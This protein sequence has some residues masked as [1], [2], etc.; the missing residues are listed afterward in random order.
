MAARLELLKEQFFDNDGAV[1][2]GGLLYTYV[3]GTTTEKATYTTAL[4]DVEQANPVVLDT[5]G[6]VATDLYGV[7][8]YKIVIKDS[9]E[10]TIDTIP[11]VSGVNSASFTTI[12]DYSGDLDAAITAISTT[13]TTLYIN[14]AATM[15]AAVTV[16]TTCKIVVLTGGSINQSTYAL[17]ING[18]F[19]A[20]PKQVFTGSGTV[21]FGLISE[22][23]VE[24]MGNIDGTA[25]D[26][27]I[28]LAIGA[29]AN[30]QTIK[31][32]ASTYTCSS[33]ITLSK[34]CTFSIGTTAITSTA[35]NAFTITSDDVSIVGINRMKSKIISSGVG[36][37]GI[38][39][40]SA[41]RD[42]ITIRDLY[43]EGPSTVWVAQDRDYEDAI[44]FGASTKVGYISNVVIRDCYFYGY[45]TFIMAF[46]VKN[47]QIV[48]NIFNHDFAALR[49]INMWEP[50]GVL[51]QGNH[52]L[53]SGQSVNA[54]EI[55]GPADTKAQE[56]KIDNNTFKG[57]W[58]YEIVNFGGDRSSIV[59]NYLY[60]SATAGVQAIELKQG[61][62][63]SATTVNDITI[64]DNTIE[65][66]NTTTYAIGIKND[67]ATIA[68]TRFTIDNNTILY[69]GT[70]SAIVTT[71]AGGA[72]TYLD[73][74]NNK[75]IDSGNGTD[76][77][78]LVT[79]T[80]SARIK[81]NFVSGCGRYGIYTQG[82]DDCTISGNE[83]MSTTTSGYFISGANVLVTNNSAHDNTA[84]GISFTGDPT[85]LN[86]SGNT[87]HDNGGDD[88]VISGASYAAL[89][90][91]YPQT[92]TLT[93]TVTFNRL[94]EAGNIDSSGGAVTV[95]VSDGLYT[96]QIVTISMS[97]QTTSST[98]SVSHHVTSDPEIGTFDAVD[99][100]WT[101]I[102]TGTEWDTLGTPTCT[103]L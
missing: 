18:D 47:W 34:A 22:I 75:I 53:D 49:Q 102:W 36:T 40:A 95:T 65:L 63:E 35:E 14:S 103:F 86:F 69:G 27:Q 41:T 31:A 61:S 98:V 13:A 94:Y 9:A 62:S 4:G 38:Y 45:Q 59:N 20:P 68:M 1:L 2:S 90:N 99:E 71:T 39:T 8:A 80:D 60:S 72:I 33:T 89:G 81:D 21:T 7:G 30:S 70:S 93:G 17:A 92:Q 97:D 55:G 85:V 58:D 87:A 82:V 74:S 29:A 79:G 84:D 3:V 51:I 24:W 50:Y 19:E 66:P 5:T 46:Y 10:T 37:H 73:I 78:T 57:A 101:L 15:S 28:N 54:I 25:D 91:N 16:P 32:H 52:F 26:V 83:V 6:R 42:G 67:S 88:F 44:I 56:C 96:G 12:G 48:N 43:F 64:A 11:T 23:V 76:G 77:M 100:T